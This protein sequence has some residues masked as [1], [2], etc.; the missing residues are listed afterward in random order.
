M[1]M[2]D[3]KYVELGQSDAAFSA[4]QLAIEL[5][6]ELQLVPEEEAMRIGPKLQEEF[7]SFREDSNTKSGDNPGKMVISDLGG[8]G[9]GQ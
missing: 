7:Q 9:S 1:S 5:N 2:W 8:G 4:F 6:P 3:A